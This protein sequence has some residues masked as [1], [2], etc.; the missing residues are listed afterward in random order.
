VAAP[1]GRRRCIFTSA[2]DRNNVAA[3][4]GAPGRSWDLLTS[5]YGADPAVAR[6]LTGISEMFLA[7][8]GAKFQN[9]LAFHRANPGV[10]ARYDHVWVMDDDLV[11]DPADLD[12]MFDI[13]E[14]WD[15]WVCQPA[16]DTRGKISHPLTGPE[17]RG[18]LLRITSFVEVTCPLFR[19]DKLIHFLDEHYDGSLV[20]FGIDHW[21]GHALGA[22]HHP[23][24][25]IVDPV[26]VLNP[27]DSAKD[28]VREINRLQK[29]KQRRAAWDAVRAARGI[30]Q[31]R[32]QTLARVNCPFCLH[33]PARKPAA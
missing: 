6:A 17:G 3:W 15:L 22:L 25:A 13:A 19:T 24:F 2:G 33:G 11:L 31:A 30:R 21:F 18:D 12:R 20:G 26:R 32:L 29:P 1:Q 7:R 27:L 28:G 9:L 23:K 8:A 4:L 10:L 16:F 14:Y 5:Y